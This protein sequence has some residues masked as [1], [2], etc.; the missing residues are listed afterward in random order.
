MALTREEAVELLQEHV[1]NERMLN[2]CVATEAVLMAL[3]EKL[4]R[5]GKNGGWQVSCT[6][7]ISN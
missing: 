2:H 1:K 4:G 6:T 7:S 5:T 3:A